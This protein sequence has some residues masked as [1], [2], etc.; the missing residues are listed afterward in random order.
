MHCHIYI[1]L[2]FIPLYPPYDTTVSISVNQ[3]IY[4]LH[5]GDILLICPGELH[6]ILPNDSKYINGLQFSPALLNSRPELSNHYHL[7]I[8]S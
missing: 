1:E 2:L 4:T 3:D 5:R 6:E 8:S 7:F